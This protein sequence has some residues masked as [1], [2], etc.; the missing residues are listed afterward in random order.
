MS[1]LVE[2]GKLV[3]FTLA[4]NTNG[5]SSSGLSPASTG[6]KEPSGTVTTP[7]G[8]ATAIPLRTL[9]HKLV[10]GYV[11]ETLHQRAR[12]SETETLW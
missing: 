9:L 5:P 3:G 1:C 6:W 11:M 7:G 12:Q 10:L 8:A 2:S 4:G